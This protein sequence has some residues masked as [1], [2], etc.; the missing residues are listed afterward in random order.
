MSDSEEATGI[1]TEEHWYAKFRGD[2]NFQPKR[3]RQSP[4]PSPV[5]DLLAER[6]E[7]T[8]HRLK[9]DAHWAMIFRGA[10]RND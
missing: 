9:T 1:K 6:V 7:P 4:P 5:V 8:G 10:R 3:P 2:P